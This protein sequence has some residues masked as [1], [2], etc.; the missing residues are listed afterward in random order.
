MLVCARVCVC[1]SA[2]ACVCGC[3]CSCACVWGSL[4]R[5]M[6]ILGPQLARLRLFQGSEWPGPG[7]QGQS[8]A[9]LPLEKVKNVKKVKVKKVKK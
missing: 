3:A 7:G 9:Q 8:E 1:V 4:I 6:N 2:L 5:K